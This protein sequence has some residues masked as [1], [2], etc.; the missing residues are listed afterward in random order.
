MNDS[1]APEL[2]ELM[3]RY[4]RDLA[5]AAPS[6]DLDARI[7]ILVA[8]H[9]TR[10]APSGRWH[11]A[12]A[13]AAAAGFAAVAITLGLVLGMRYERALEAPSPDARAPLSWS[14]ADLA[15][16]PTDSVAFRIPAEYDAHGGIVAVDP[17]GRA[18]ARYWVEVVVS[19]DGTA[20]IAR[21]VPAA[22]DDADEVDT[23]DLA[24]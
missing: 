6:P 1:P 5:R 8:G 9:R 4:A 24:L 23:D 12:A 14:T 19:N 21:I 10:Q 18:S 16:W 17:K 13:W 11:A 2:R 7:A 3:T 20:R 15:M 22:A